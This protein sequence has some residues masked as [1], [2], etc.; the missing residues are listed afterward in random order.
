M[1]HNCVTQLAVV[2]CMADLFQM[3]TWQK[4]W[5]YLS[6]VYFLGLRPALWEVRALRSGEQSLLSVELAEI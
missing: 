5:V 6:Q 1:C 2:F 3:H 4:E